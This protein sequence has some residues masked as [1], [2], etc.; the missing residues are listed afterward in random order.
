MQYHLFK[1]HFL[2]NFKEG[3]LKTDYIYNK[4]NILLQ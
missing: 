4:Y 2:P 1:V 3:F